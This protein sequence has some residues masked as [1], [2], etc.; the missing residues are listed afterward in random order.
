MED[1]L[2]L[3]NNGALQIVQWQPGLPRYRRNNLKGSGFDPEFISFSF[4]GTNNIGMPLDAVPGK[5]APVSA[6]A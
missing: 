4:G 6:R 2:R 1:L 3:G 5:E